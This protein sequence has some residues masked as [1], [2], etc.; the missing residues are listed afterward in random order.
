MEDRRTKDRRW[1]L[2]AL[3]LFFLWVAALSFMAALSAS[4][5]ATRPNSPVIR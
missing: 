1:F 2:A 4:R 3:A 5:P